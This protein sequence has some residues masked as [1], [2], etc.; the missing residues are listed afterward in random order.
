MSK[1]LVT[2]ILLPIITA[3]LAGGCSQETST[4]PDMSTL[5]SQRL[6]EAPIFKEVAIVY[7]GTSP[8]AAL[9]AAGATITD[10]FNHFPVIAA[11]VPTDVIGKLRNNPNIIAVEEDIPRELCAQIVP[12]GVD[13]I[14]ADKVHTTFGNRGAG[15]NVAII[16]TG[17]DMDHPDL[18]FAGG[19]TFFGRDRTDFD[20]EYGHGT[21]CAGIVGA[22]D[23]DLG[24]LGVAPEC[25]LWMVKI[26]KTRRVNLMKIVKGI[27]WCIETHF[28]GDPNNDIQIMSMSFSGGFSA[29]ESTAVH[30]AWDEGILPI[31]AAGNYATAVRY[32]AALDNCMAISGSTITDGW[33][34]S[35]CYGDEIELIAPAVSVLSTVPDGI[36][37]T[38]TGTSMACPHVAGT[39]ALIWSDNPAF[40]NEDVRNK[41]N[42]TAEDI[43][44]IVERQGN[45]LVDAE[46][47]VLGT[48]KGDD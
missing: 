13:R 24:V 7:R 6:A 28:D 31:A 34:T 22:K 35:S 44:M 15:V 8:R 19:V 39:A 29:A 14:D 33:Y 25:N 20:D 2:L 18:N 1:K 3:L 37:S 12:W 21:H 5:V 16:D 47:A 45:G 40:T 23:N 9:E 30:S 41:L 11:Y 36:Y 38:M 4:S 42:T 46:N 48:T 32:P 27:E 10:D 17:G 26:A 43:G